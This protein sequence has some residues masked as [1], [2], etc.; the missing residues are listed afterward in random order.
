MMLS[1]LLTL[2]NHILR[3]MLK[4]KRSYQKCFGKKS[5]DMTEKKFQ[6]AANA[7]LS[8]ISLSQTPE[9]RNQVVTD[10]LKRVFCNMTGEIEDLKYKL[11]TTESHLHDNEI[12]D[13]I[14]AIHDQYQEEIAFLKMR[15]YVASGSLRL[16]TDLIF[17]DFDNTKKSN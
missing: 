3:P 17:E 13:D 5:K 1:L 4:V 14:E 11:K 7:I 9:T 2:S 10:I 15:L 16:L 8:S 12:A 6:D